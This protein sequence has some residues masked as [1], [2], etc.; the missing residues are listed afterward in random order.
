MM[1]LRWMPCISKPSNLI[2]LLRVLFPFPY[3]R[4]R[5]QTS[6]S[7]AGL[8]FFKAL[9]IAIAGKICPPGAATA[10]NDAVSTSAA[11]S[12]EWALNIFN[13]LKGEVFAIGCYVLVPAHVI[14]FI[15]PIS[16]SDYTDFLSRALTSNYASLISPTITFLRFINIATYG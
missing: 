10:D 5:L 14:Y 1:D 11:R 7:V 3:G 6:I 4:W 13:S 16:F 8:S 9:A 12:I 15:S 2:T